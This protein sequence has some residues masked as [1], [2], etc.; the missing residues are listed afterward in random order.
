MFFDLIFRKARLGK[1][2]LLSFI[3]GSVLLLRK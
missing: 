2:A 1:N 3:E